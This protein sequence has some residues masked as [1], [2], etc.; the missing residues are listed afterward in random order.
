MA[1]NAPGLTPQE[2]LKCCK[3]FADIQYGLKALKF[4]LK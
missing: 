3:V 2:A 4:K 1:N